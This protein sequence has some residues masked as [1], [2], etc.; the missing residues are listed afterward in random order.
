MWDKPER[1]LIE[2]TARED[3]SEQIAVLDDEQPAMLAIP[4]DINRL[5]GEALKMHARWYDDQIAKADYADTVLAD[6]ETELL[7]GGVA[8]GTTLAYSSEV[9]GFSAAV[10]E[11]RMTLEKE[12]QRRREAQYDHAYGGYSE[13]PD[14]GDHSGTWL[15]FMRIEELRETFG[16]NWLGNGFHIVQGNGVRR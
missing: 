14:D 12:D 5:H 7:I 10:D 6:W 9:S 13:D 1:D 4:E 2:R 15:P 16:Q 3:I 8:E 11:A